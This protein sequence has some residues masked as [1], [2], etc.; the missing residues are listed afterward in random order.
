MKK[1]LIILLAILIL[2]TAYVFWKTKKTNIDLP[3]NTACTEEA[4]MCPDGSGV[5]RTGPECKF[6]P[7]PNTAESYTGTLLQQGGD[8]F[9]VIAASEKSSF[10][11]NF[12]LP[13]KIK[14]SNILGQLVGQQVS[15]KGKFIEGTIFEIE[16][17]EESSGAYGIPNAIE[18][19]IG[20]TAYMNG[21]KIT[22]HEVVQDNRCPV[23]VT[24]IEGGAIT[25]KVTLKSNTD[26]ETFNMPSDEVPHT[27]DSY[28]VSIVNVKPSR[29]SAS[30][31]EPQSY[32]VTF[33][34]ENL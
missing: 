11:V 28:K 18:V 19:G 9:L 23:D 10:E 29:I 16:S 13:L 15:V 34:V 12:A 21:V 1:V 2:G 33:K 27:F 30:E 25:A 3:N 14:I 8:F 6:S 31:P 20:E 7:C 5:G 17:L 26:T 4:L 32:K 24:C 22:L